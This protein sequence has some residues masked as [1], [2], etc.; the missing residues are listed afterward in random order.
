VKRREFIAGLGSTATMWPILARAQQSTMP[1]IGYLSARSADSEQPILA[2]FT[3]SLSKTGYV[4][5]KDV[6]IEF[7]WANGQYSRLAAL[8]DDLVH[9]QVNVIVAVGGE[10]S[11]LAAKAATAT[12]P[13]V[14]NVGDPLSVGLVASLG[15][16][17][18]NATGLASLLLALGAKQFGFLRELVPKAT[19]IAMLVNPLDPWMISLSADAQAGAR[20]VGQE[21]IILNASTEREIDA[22]FVVAIQQGVGALLVSPGP[23]FVAEGNHLIALAARHRLPA[24]YSRREFAEAG[25]LISYGSSTDELSG[26]MA[27]YVAKI[28]KGSKPSDLPIVQPT[29]FELVINMKAAKALGL[30]VPL[31]L[32]QLADE[33]IE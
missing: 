13:I 32:Q 18:G 5:D 29:K 26:H 3:R 12:I 6:A 9:R 11:A 16:P 23:F 21:L 8:A 2:A 10:Q 19:K 33:V 14:F 30:E 1:V 27:T 25:G 7:R 20:A 24:I 17:G 31:N 4:V 22:A 28:L 15:R